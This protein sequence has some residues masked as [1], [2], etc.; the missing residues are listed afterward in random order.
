MLFFFLFFKYVTFLCLAHYPTV[1]SGSVSMSFSCEKIFLIKWSVLL[2][3]PGIFILF[4]HNISQM[5]IF[6]ILFFLLQQNLF[7]VKAATDL[8]LLTIVI[9]NPTKM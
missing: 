9:F 7:S 5:L 4:C 2:G 3:I 6:K 8:I 1:I